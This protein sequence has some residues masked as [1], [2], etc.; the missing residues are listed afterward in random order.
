MATVKDIKEKILFMQNC[1]Y[2]LNRLKDCII[3]HKKYDA[4]NNDYV[5]SVDAFEDEAGLNVNLEILCFNAKE[6]IEKEIKRLEMI[7][8]NT[9]L[10]EKL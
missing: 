2:N 4:Q 1:V 7:I 3:N 9:K 5:K 8:D 6:I 10:E